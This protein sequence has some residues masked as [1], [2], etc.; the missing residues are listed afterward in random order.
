LKQ[1]QDLLCL[2]CFVPDLAARGVA[3]PAGGA[4]DTR[5]WRCDEAFGIKVILILA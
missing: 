2:P 5:G 4:V 3:F 1:F